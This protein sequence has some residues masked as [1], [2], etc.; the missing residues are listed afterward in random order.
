MKI[1]NVRFA[2]WVGCQ[3]V[4]GLDGLRIL[5]VCESHYGA[6]K[7]ERPTATPEIVKALALGE[8]HPLATKRLRRHPHFTKIMRAVT[9]TRRHATRDDK[10]EFWSRVAYY[11]F[12]QEFIR[13][14]RITPRENSWK[15]GEDAFSDVLDVLVPDL[16]VCL[17]LRNGRRIRSLAGN[18]PV[19]VVNHPSSRFTYSN[20]NSVVARGKQNALLHK[21]AKQSFFRSDLFDRWSKAT[22]S[23]LPAP[24]AH[25]SQEHAASLLTQRQ[26]AM[27]ELDGTI[28][29]LY[30]L[31]HN[32]V[33]VGEPRGP[34][35]AQMRG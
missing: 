28:A 24:G 18:T 9:N 11:N 2:P 21:T 1:T 4:D 31:T 32:V 6:K 14:K 15:S 23:A 10:A 13:D 25:L 3:Y 16:I 5:L 19:A 17:S 27:K 7:H 30:R 35:P 29:A 33:V 20:V 12:I 26:R 34:F 8:M 22:D